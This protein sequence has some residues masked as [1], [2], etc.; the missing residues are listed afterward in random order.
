LKAAFPAPAGLSSIM[1]ARLGARVQLTDHSR[2]VLQLARANAARNGVAGGVQVLALDRAR[3]LLV[4]HGS[5]TLELLAELL[6]APRPGGAAAAAAGP[7]PAAAPGQAAAAG[8]EERHPAQGSGS[9]GR[10]LG[11]TQEALQQ[12]LQT[13]VLLAADTVYDEVLTE[14]F[15]CCAAYVMAC[16][17]LARRQ[18]PGAAA[19]GLGSGQARQAPPPPAAA[20][21]QGGAS[22]AAGQRCQADDGPVLLLAMEKRYN[23][24]LRECEERAPA[25]DHLMRFLAR[26]DGQPSQSGAGS[27]L[28]Q[29]PLFTYRELQVEQVPQVCACGGGGG[30]SAAGQVAAPST[31]APPAKRQTAAI[32]EHGGGPL[33]QLLAPHP[34]SLPASTGHALPAL[35]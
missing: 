26:D 9:S 25:F 30:G 35:S 6:G 24:T 12:L 3:F 21:A 7:A 28:A 11:W 27:A 19:E 32:P 20:Q 1:A 16:I 5:A 17:R 18:A 23:F 31:A 22:A 34:P 8:Q 4:P 14:A 33:L 29:R 2:E 10:C 13:Q 15:L